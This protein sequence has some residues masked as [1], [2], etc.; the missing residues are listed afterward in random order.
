M[1]LYKLVQ[2]VLTLSLGIKVDKGTGTRT[3]YFTWSKTTIDGLIVIQTDSG[4]HKAPLVQVN[5]LET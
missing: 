2:E 3:A 4:P 5:L 1:M